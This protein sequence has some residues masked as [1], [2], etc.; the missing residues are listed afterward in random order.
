MEFATGCE[1][2]LSGRYLQNTVSVDFS[3]TAFLLSGMR[4]SNV[5]NFHTVYVV[6]DG[7]AGTGGGGAADDDDAATAAV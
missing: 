6:D 5:N 2:R 7:G 3:P 1:F 4:T